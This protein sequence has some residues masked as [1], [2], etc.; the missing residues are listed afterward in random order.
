[1]DAGWTAVSILYIHIREYILLDQRAAAGS[2]RLPGPLGHSMSNAKTRALALAVLAAAATASSAAAEVKA[3]HPDGLQAFVHGAPPDPTPAW[4]LAAGGR[5]YDTWWDALDRKKPSGTNPAYPTT[6]K[7]T[8]ATTWRCV[9]CHGWDYKGKDGLYRDGERYTGIKGIRAAEGRDVKAIA[10]ALRVEPHNYTSE[11]IS[12][13]ELARVAAFVAR[14][15]H[16]VDR[17]ID[18]KT[19]RALG[20]GRRGAALFQTTCAACHGFDGRALNWGDKD[21]PAYIGTEAS[22]L[23]AEVLHKIRNSHP[24]AAMINLR[25]LP[26]KDAVDVLTYAQTLPTK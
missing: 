7:R 8:G 11:M 1:M 21:G 19:N 18:A 26:I 22:K 12:D 6:G 15:Q 25:A 5:I 17:F 20:D 9:E 13:E 14:G 2:D 16:E 23:P 3:K 10:R 24:G 4:T